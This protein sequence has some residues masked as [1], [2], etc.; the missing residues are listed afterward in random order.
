MRLRLVIFTQITMHESRTKLLDAALHVFRAKGYAATTIEDVCKA[1][2]LTKGSF[3]HHFTGKEELALAAAN[4]FSTVTASLFKSAPYHA[5][6]DP[7]ERVLGYIDFRAAILKGDLPQFTCLLGTLVQ[8]T[9]QTHPAIR[10]AC[11]QGISDHI[12]D[13]A[14]DIALAKAM[15]ASDAP[16]S[17]QGVA[18]YTQAVL[19]GAFVL[20]KAKGGPEIASE[21]V[22]HLHRYLRS[23]FHHPTSKETTQ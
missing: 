20:A 8:E 21:C 19:Q 14:K 17:A 5:P 23:L 18:T 1:A 6:S 10:S 2:G 13:V 15:Y 4:H 7:F 12:A 3:F 9:Y 16:W 11:E 22:V